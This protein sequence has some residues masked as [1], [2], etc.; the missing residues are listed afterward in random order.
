[1][2]VFLLSSIQ[3][4]VEWQHCIQKCTNTSWTKMHCHMLISSYLFCTS[5]AHCGPHSRQLCD[6][7]VGSQT[8]FSI[9][10]SNLN[11]NLA[12]FIHE[13]CVYVPVSV[14]P[15]Y[16]ILHPFT[17]VKLCRLTSNSVGKGLVRVQT[18]ITICMPA[19]NDVIS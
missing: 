11:L 14:L 5:Q 7:S 4:A 9:C 17:S 12:D 8:L 6:L 2:T 18:L 16:C 15:L 19:A 13:V 3:R 1:M 10:R